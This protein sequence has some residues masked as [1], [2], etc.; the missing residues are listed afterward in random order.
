MYKE[1]VKLYYKLKYDPRQAQIDAL[2]FTKHQ[3]RRGKKFVMLNMPTGVG[4]AQPLYS[5]ILTPNGWKKLGKLKLHDSIITPNGEVNKIIQLHPITKLDTYIIEFSDGRKIECTKNHLWKAHSF[6]WRNN[7]WRIVNTELLYKKFYSK[8][9]KIHIPLISNTHNFDKN[10]SLDPYLL[11]CLLGDGGITNNVILTSAD[12]FIV[13]KIKTIISNDFIDMKVN[14]YSKYTYG[15]VYKNGKLN[16]IKKILKD[17]KLHG[18]KSEKKFI[19][20]VYKNISYN[21]KIELINGLLDTDGYVCKNGTVSFSSSSYQLITDLQE[22]IWSIGGIA[23]LKLKKSN[24]KYKDEK[25]K[26]QH[27]I[28]S[29]RY[30]NPRELVSLPR[31]KDRISKKYQYKDLKLKI[32]NI[33]KTNNKESCRCITIDSDEQL[34]ITDNYIV[35]HNSFYSVMFMN[36]YKNYINKGAK[37]DILTNTKLL[38]NQY[39]GEFPFIANLKGKNAYKCNSYPDS[40]CQEG[41]EMNAALK[42]SCTNCPYDRDMISWR[43]EDVAMT[44]FHLFD[45]VNL[46]LPDLMVAKEP[47]V[48]IIDEAHD[49]ES[50]LCDFISMKISRRAL[51][52]IGFN[53]VNI[54]EVARELKDDVSTIDDYEQYVSNI[55]IHKLKSLQTSLESRLTSQLSQAER[56]RYSKNLSNLKGTIVNFESFVSDYK[57]NP[58]NWV[59]DIEFNSKDKQFVND[60]VVQPV[61]SYDYLKEIIWDKYD[62]VILMSGT[63]LDKNM[64]SYIN[65][66][67]PKLSAYYEMPTPFPLKR[68]PIY[69]IKVGKMT[70]NQKEETFKKQIPYIDKILK[71]NSDKK[72]IIHTANYEISNWLKEYYGEKGRL[73]FHTSEDRNEALNKHLISDIPTVIVSPSMMNGVDLKDDLSRFQIIMKIPYPNIKSNKMK[74]RMK[75]N[76]KFYNWKTV[77]DFIQAYGRSIRSMEDWAETY[78]LDSSLSDILKFNYNIIPTYVTDAIKLLKK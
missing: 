27:Y 45:T 36:W 72:G 24:Y 38:Q 34:Y 69:Y 3:I 40:S 48:L 4:K 44:N 17:Y 52:R 7:H 39:I 71:R 32:T 15:I 74:K 21:Q 51:K 1:D 64:F 20:N 22:I 63:I 76:K 28:L 57:N 78:V 35:T 58:N 56:L 49:F 53:E 47:N 30:K 12:D 41:K 50:V 54:A 60:Y 16:P 31:K 46:F 66:L 6:D 10:L 70:F 65:G 33:T 13:N 5:N 37:F 25:N 73:I 19:P 8:S 43:T 59:L 62:H 61:W 11:G 29:I 75:D 68:R 9:N 67:E 18:L 55:F 77:V 42:R 26:K 14:K 23:K 2:E